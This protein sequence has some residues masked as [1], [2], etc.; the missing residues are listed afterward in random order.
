MLIE[1]GADLDATDTQGWTTLMHE[2][3]NGNAAATRELI[4]AGADTWVFLEVDADAARELIAD[5]ADTWESSGD[6]CAMDM[7]TEGHH[8]DCAIAVAQAR[9]DRRK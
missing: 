6:K 1:A 5:G 8:W 7:A 4:A 2:C 9:R 3:H